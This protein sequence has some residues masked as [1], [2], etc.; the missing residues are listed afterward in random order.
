[1]TANNIVTEISSRSPPK[2]YF[3]S[4][5][6]TTNPTPSESLNPIQKYGKNQ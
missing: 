4:V 1:M 5:Q 3:K 2:N 6:K